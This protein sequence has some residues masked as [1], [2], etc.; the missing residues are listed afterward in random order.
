MADQRPAAFWRLKLR[1]SLLTARKDRDTARIAALRSA[2]S[3]I[4]NAETP[5]PVDIKT[6]SSGTIAGS[7]AGLG[8]TEVARRELSDEQI[9]DLLRAEI[10]E[11]LNAAEDFSAAGHSERV[12]ALRAEAATLIDLMG[13]G[14]KP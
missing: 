6:G 1:E 9:R 3:A 4:D 14:A 5:E 13:R 11:R 7:V 2:L 10:D 12:D 8:A